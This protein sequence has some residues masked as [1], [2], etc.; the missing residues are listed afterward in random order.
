MKNAPVPV[1]PGDLN[2]V[3]VKIRA[4]FSKAPDNYF[5]P[6]R[7]GIARKIECAVRDDPARWKAEFSQTNRSIH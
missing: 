1:F 2:G 4:E 7:T 3:F 6:S 5:Y